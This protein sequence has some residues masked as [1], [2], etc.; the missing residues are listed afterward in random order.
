MLLR[1]IIL[2]S[3]IFFTSTSIFSHPT[4]MNSYDFTNLPNDTTLER[5]RDENNPLYTIN[6][7]QREYQEKISLL[8][9]NELWLKHNIS[10]LKTLISLVDSL[11]LVPQLIE[12]G[13][14]SAEKLTLLINNITIATVVLTDFIYQ[15]KNKSTKK[16]EIPDFLNGTLIN[17]LTSLIG[18]SIGLENQI[19]LELMRK[20]ELI[21]YALLNLS[22]TNLL[23]FKMHIADF[24]SNDPELKNTH[25]V[26][27]EQKIFSRWYE[28]IDLN[29]KPLSIYNSI[30]GQLW[31]NPTKG[32]TLSEKRKTKPIKQLYVYA[33][34]F[35]TLFL[36]SQ[37]QKKLQ[38]FYS[39]SQRNYLT[40]KKLKKSQ[41]TR[42][43]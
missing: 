33:H 37:I 8:K 14:I 16:P 6:F 9:D 1:K 12:D 30:L 41:I 18:H 38:N 25:K 17:D 2:F 5:L 28:D 19:Y 27:I 43:S 42:R 4:K 31:T 36:L 20:C 21:I 35:Q 39:T 34:P 11:S 23:Y 10:R 26:I 29:N 3:V 24:T 32:L 15:N 22:K 7:T 13:K 40:Q